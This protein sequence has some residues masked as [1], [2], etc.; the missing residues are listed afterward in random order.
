MT[1]QFYNDIETRL[2][3]LTWFSYF[4]LFNNQF[5]MME[6]QQE[7]PFPDLSIFM[8]FVKPVPVIT[9]GLGLK[10]YDATVRFHLYFMSL[11]LQ[12]LNVLEKK[13]DLL[14]LLDGFMPTRSSALNLINEEPDQNHNGYMVWILEFETQIP[15]DT[16]KGV[17]NN[18]I[19]IAPVQLDL[20]GDLIIDNE[21]IRTGKFP[22]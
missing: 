9:A 1:L 11:E 13:N 20:T 6:Q 5:E 8:E 12:D 14:A 2:Q 21:V 4:K 7:Q 3:E 17:Y 15:I 16:A 18:K 19:D 22:S 10:I